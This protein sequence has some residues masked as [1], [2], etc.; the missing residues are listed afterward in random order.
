VLG[1]IDGSVLGM[2]VGALLGSLEGSLLPALVGLRLGALDGS[3]L[4]L[5]DG[6]EVLGDPDGSARRVQP[7]HRLHLRRT[8]E[9]TLSLNCS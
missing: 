1:D 2:V 5:E 9:P 6:S 3:R 4:G 8:V 7:T